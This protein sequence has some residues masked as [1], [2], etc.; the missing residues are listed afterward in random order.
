MPVSPNLLVHCSSARQQLHKA[1]RRDARLA[2]CKT[3]AK[4]IIQTLLCA[5]T[6]PSGTFTV[7]LAITHVRDCKPLALHQKS[8]KYASCER[9]GHTLLITKRWM[10]LL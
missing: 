6:L 5:A 1:I 9:L 3:V 8:K 10:T 7:M 2:I 4:C